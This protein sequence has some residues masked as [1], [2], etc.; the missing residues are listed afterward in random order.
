MEELGVVSE[1]DLGG[2]ALGGGSICGIHSP[3][4]IISCHCK[5]FGTAFKNRKINIFWSNVMHRF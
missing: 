1:G 4:L 5:V 3:T 2:I